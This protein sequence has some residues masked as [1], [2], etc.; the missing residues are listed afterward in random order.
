MGVGRPDGLG[1]VPTT[2]EAIY[3]HSRGSPHD[4]WIWIS[5]ISMIDKDGKLGFPTSREDI[6]RFSNIM[7]K[8]FLRKSPLELQ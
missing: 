3:S 5:K 8:V 7:R 2:H 1:H 4:K 6:R